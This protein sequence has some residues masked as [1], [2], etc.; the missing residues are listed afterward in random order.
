MDGIIQKYENGTLGVAWQA[1]K[2]RSS[3]KSANSEVDCN[4][5][6]TKFQGNQKLEELHVAA[7]GSGAVCVLVQG[8]SG[9]GK[10]CLLR[11]YAAICGRTDGETL[12]VVH[13]GEQIDSKILLGTFTCTAV[14]GEFVW[15]PGLLTKCVLAGHWIVLEDVDSAPSDVISLLL[16]LVKSRTLNIPGYNEAIPASPGFKLFLTKRI[17]AGG[18]F[19]PG[20]SGILQVLEQ[21]SIKLTLPQLSNDEVQKVVADEFPNLTNFRQQLAGA[22]SEHDIPLRHVLKLCRRISQQVV[23]GC[24]TSVPDMMLEVVDCCAG[25]LSGDEKLARAKE[26][27]YLCGGLSEDMVHACIH[28][29]SF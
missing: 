20:H 5:L 29:Y 18:G 8:P 12:M 15:L 11:E 6:W 22:I 2:Q 4:K 28:A 26:L 13:L 19:G 14:P 17:S 27:S 16:P 23:H 25:H 21:H 24:L 3:M 10:S 9:C 7:E 1:L